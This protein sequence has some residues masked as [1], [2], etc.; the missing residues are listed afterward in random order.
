[1]A[2]KLIIPTEGPCAGHPCDNCRIC[3]SGRCCRRD[4][5]DYKLPGLGEWDGPIYGELGVLADDGQKV[6]CHCCGEWFVG[7]GHHIVQHDLT[8]EE[9]KAIFGLSRNRGLA[10]P[11]TIRALSEKKKNEPNNRERMSA[12]AKAFLATLTPEQRNAI[13]MVPRRLQWRLS[14]REASWPSQGE[15]RGP[16]KLSVEHVRD[17]LSITPVPNTWDDYKRLAQEYG[18]HV[19]TIK[20]ILWGDTWRHIGEELGIAYDDPSRKP[21]MQPHTKPRKDAKLTPDDV[22]AIR[23]RAP[24]T[25]REMEQVAEEYG[26]CRALISHILRG[27]SWGW[28]DGN[29]VAA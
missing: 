1:M 3:R 27:Y 9:Y 25:T 20:N 5:P 19:N 16:S 8:K 15:K 12:M 4:N 17:L 23:R 22:R 11:A 6:E 10:A 13:A 28:L 2:T 21:S 24:K 29:E 26:V 7:L 14:V 18:V